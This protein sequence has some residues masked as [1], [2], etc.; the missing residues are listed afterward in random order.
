MF[1]EQH[2]LDVDALKE[3]AARVELDRAAFDA[4]L[5]SGRHAEQVQEDIRQGVT[6]GVSG[7]PA[8]FVNGIPV[9]G[10]AVPYELLSEMIDDELGRIDAN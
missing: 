5:D 9:P 3:K 1:D 7:T 8:V 4:C 10:G 2:Q 6:V